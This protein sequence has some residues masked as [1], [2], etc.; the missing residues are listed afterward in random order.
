[1][2]SDTLLNAALAAA[3]A[4]IGA[5]ASS[6][7]QVPVDDYLMATILSVI[8]IVARHSYEA[9]KTDRNF[10]LRTFSIDLTT[11]PML[12]IVAYIGCIFFNV[13]PLV[14]PGIVI[15]L[16]FLGPE[17]VRLVGASVVDVV[18]GRIKGGKLP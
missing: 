4:T 10:N 2:A 7:F 6:A 18:S 9:S 5:A 8:G 12:G 3:P 16:S 1:M 15:L 13:A 11:A 17:A 14:A